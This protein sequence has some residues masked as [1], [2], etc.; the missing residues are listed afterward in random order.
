[1]VKRQSKL[2]LLEVPLQ[3][4]SL[5]I[6]GVEHIEI[7]ANGKKQIVPAPL[8]PYVLSKQKMRIQAS[9]VVDV[10]EVTIKP[11]DTLEPTK[12][13][14]YSFPAVDYIRQLNSQLE[15]NFAKQELYSVM[16]NHVRFVERVAIDKP[17]FYRQ[18]PED[19]DSWLCFDIETLTDNYIDKKKIIAIS[20]NDG[21]KTWCH[22][23]SE[24]EI[25]ENFIKDWKRLD[26]DVVITFNGKEFDFPYI[27][28]RC[29]HHKL[30]TNWIG[31]DNRPT[32]T[33][34]PTGR[35]HRIAPM[36]D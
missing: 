31:R 27:V 9:D 19:L 30:P 6:N 4:R 26:P 33:Y 8:K 3:A 13:W 5:Q 29:K 28:R 32:Q 24:K 14:K 15:K 34:G 2:Q 11:I 17:D 36:K 12:A 25:L 1:V 35:I 18:F 21:S 16:E 10:D 22:I 23:G 20:I 7:W